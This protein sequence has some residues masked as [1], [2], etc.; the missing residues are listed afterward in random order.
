MVG[1]PIFAIGEENK[2]R[3]YRM[4]TLDEWIEQEI[5][6]FHFRYT[7]FDVVLLLF[8]KIIIIMSVW[9]VGPY[10]SQASTLSSLAHIPEKFAMLCLLYFVMKAILFDVQA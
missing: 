5:T 1:Y 7:L 6:D 2:D 9:S 8:I 3:G 10:L 4:T